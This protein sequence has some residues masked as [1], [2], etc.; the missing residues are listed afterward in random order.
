MKRL[1]NKA[2]IRPLLLLSALGAGSVMTQLVPSS[3]NVASNREQSG[4]SVREADRNA[5]PGVTETDVNLRHLTRVGCI[6]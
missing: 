1:E 5:S 3:D 6:A 4:S 2:W